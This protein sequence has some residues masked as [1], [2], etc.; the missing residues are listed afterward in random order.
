MRP[1]LAELTRPTREYVGVDYLWERPTISALWFKVEPE[2]RSATTVFAYL[3]QP[4]GSRT[5]RRPGVVLIHGGGG[6]AFPEW[7]TMW[8]QRGY[9]ALAID[10]SGS[11]PSRGLAETAGPPQSAEGKFGSIRDGVEHTWMVHA[12][13]A[14]RHALSVLGA[15]PDVD[16]SQLYLTGISWGSHVAQLVTS[17]DERVRRAAFVYGAGFHSENSYTSAYLS[18][19]PDADA[20]LWSKMFDQKHYLAQ[21]AAPTLWITGVNDPHYRLDLFDR[22][23]RLVCAPVTRHVSLSLRHSHEEGWSPVEIAAFFAESAQ[24]GPALPVLSPPAIV[25]GRL[26]STVRFD[27]PDR[28]A[29]LRYTSSRGSWENKSWE[30]RAADLDG[31]LISALLPAGW[32][33]AYL[34]AEDAS[35]IRVSTS[36]VVPALGS[37]ST[38]S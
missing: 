32:T 12:V 13:S 21:I 27:L 14:A 17:V 11:T 34:E 20:A 37:T 30:S 15:L 5:S 25:D 9:A 10:L 38:I 23:A 2:S 36:L 33:S 24:A 7:A 4:S 26:S 3:A 19:L 16:A 35:G 28:G 18:K 6:R 29:T 8:A 1:S 31:D 22:S